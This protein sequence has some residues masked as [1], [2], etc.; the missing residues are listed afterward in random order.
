MSILACVAT[1]E[2]V[3][4]GFAK[5][6]QRPRWRSKIVSR[7][8]THRLGALRILCLHPANVQ[9]H[10]LHPIVATHPPRRRWRFHHARHG[11]T[12]SPAWPPIR[13]RHACVR[14]HVARPDYRR[15]VDSCL[16]AATAQSDPAHGKNIRARPVHRS[17]RRRPH[18][19]TKHDLE[20]FC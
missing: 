12:A 18:R 15:I 20:L 5:A 1:G 9:P 13:L 2:I 6:V 4:A 8:P 19:R 17:L 10:F 3:S 14:R 7:R 16:V 11:G